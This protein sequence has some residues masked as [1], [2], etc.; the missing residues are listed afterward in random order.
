V[1]T[2]NVLGAGRTALVTGASRGIG[3]LIARRIANYGGHVVLTARS[4]ADLKAVASEHWGHMYSVPRHRGFIP[5]INRKAD[6][7]YRM[8]VTVAQ[9]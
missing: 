5:G 2:S 3:P 4:G 9:L 8:C 1:S 7:L 6:C